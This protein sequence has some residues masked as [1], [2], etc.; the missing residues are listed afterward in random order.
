M[1]NPT[2][3]VMKGIGISLVVLGHVWHS[4]AFLQKIIYAFHM[5][6]FFLISG[7]LFNEVKVR[8][9]L[10]KDFIYGRIRRLYF[11]AVVIGFSCAIP[12]LF[13]KQTTSLYDFS[14]RSFGVLYSI[15]SVEYTFNC[16]P[17]WFL[18]CLL[19]VELIYFAVCR[20]GFKYRSCLVLLL[21]SLGVVISRE[22]AVFFPFNVQIALCSLIFFYFGVLLRNYGFLEKHGNRALYFVISCAI[23]ILTTVLNPV[24]VGF[25]ANRMGDLNYLFLGSLSGSYMV[26]W[27]ALYL[28]KNKKCLWLSLLGRNTI[29]ILGYNYW[30]FCLVRVLLTKVGYSHWFLN[31][32]LQ[33]LLFGVGAIIINRLPR[34]NRLLQG[35]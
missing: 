13:F 17:I 34:F 8:G 18:S 33:L 12:S 6:L 14:I 35:S 30:M 1:R 22:Y 29:L 20:S 16:T 2:I 4:P 15:P 31:F 19:C 25:G 32:V 3:D 7:Y 11:P 24:K 26:Y 10:A 28:G 21:F 9:M 23:L 27:I 5:P